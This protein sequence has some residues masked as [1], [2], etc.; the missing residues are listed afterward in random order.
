MRSMFWLLSLYY[1]SSSSRIKTQEMHPLDKL[2]IS[3]TL[4]EYWIDFKFCTGRTKLKLIPPIF[5]IGS[6]HWRYPYFSNI[7]G[8]LHTSRNILN[9]ELGGPGILVNAY[10]L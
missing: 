3:T 7:I 5:Y 8:F 10:L 6:T 9:I 4:F 2:G 1:Y